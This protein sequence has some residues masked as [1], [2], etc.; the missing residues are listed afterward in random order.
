MVSNP[1]ILHGKHC[2]R[3]IT[4]WQVNLEPPPSSSKAMAAGGKA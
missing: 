4:N 2:L 3:K 1:E